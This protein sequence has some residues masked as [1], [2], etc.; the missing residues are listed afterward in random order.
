MFLTSVLQLIAAMGWSIM[1]FRT[2]QHAFVENREKNVTI[3][4]R[5]R[6]RMRFTHDEIPV[7]KSSFIWKF[8]NSLS[9]FSR[10]RERNPYFREK[11][12]FELVEVDDVERS[13]SVRHRRPALHL[14]NPISVWSKLFGAS[15]SY[16]RKQS[17]RR[18]FTS[19]IL[20]RAL[21]ILLPVT[22]VPAVKLP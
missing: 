5:L 1:N 17:I 19:W 9:R 7:L 14:N 3:A 6:N 4:C 21:H 20:S 2:W 18:R 8:I 22:Y 12:Y 11:K 15:T 16:V 10:C 13:P